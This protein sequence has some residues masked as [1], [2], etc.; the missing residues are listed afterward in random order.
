MCIYTGSYGLDLLP[1]C[2][3]Q[4]WGMVR[5]PTGRAYVNYKNP[6]S[7]VTAL[8]FSITVSF[9][10][11]VTPQPLL[12]AHQARAA[13]RLAPDDHGQLPGRAP[14]SHECRR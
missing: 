3:E 12:R 1:L 4:M 2:I 8:R 13:A 9:R 11:S 7:I 14:A 6:S 5:L 10:L